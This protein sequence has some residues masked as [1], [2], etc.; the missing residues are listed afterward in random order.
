MYPKPAKYRQHVQVPG[1]LNLGAEQAAKSNATAWPPG[2]VAA[3]DAA[4]D[5]YASYDAELRLRF[6]NAAGERLWGRTRA[7][8]AGKTPR[9]MFPGTAGVRLESAYQRVI[10]E[11]SAA[12]LY[13]GYAGPFNCCEERVAPAAGGGVDVWFRPVP[14]RSDN[15][16]SVLA[17]VVT[18][19]ALVADRAGNILSIN[20]AGLAFYGWETESQALR[21]FREMGELEFFQPDGQPV[22]AE[23]GPLGR[24]LRGECFAGLEFGVRRTDTGRC[25][26]GSL[27][28]DPCA[29][30]PVR[31]PGPCWRSGR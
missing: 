25:W 23:D 29:T 4:P 7:G 19:G 28:A 10:R 13:I 26:T 6:L 2:I 30:N 3:L 16:A 24:A 15:S 31:P 12:C 14:N 22:P 5:G 1:T 8:V 27:A 21:N 9:E 20:A 11:R 18:D 17:A